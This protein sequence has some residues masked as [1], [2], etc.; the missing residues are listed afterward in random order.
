MPHLASHVLSRCLA[1]LGADWTA[2]YGYAPVLA[3]TFVNP[4]PVCRDV[5]PGGQLGAGRADG[6]AGHPVSQRQSGGRAQGH[7]CVP[8]RAPLE[9]G[10]VRGAGR[11]A[12]QHAAAGGP[13]RLDRRGVWHGAA[14]RRPPQAPAVHAGRRLLCAARRAGAA[15][16]RTARQPRRR[17]RTDFSRIPPWICTPCSGRT[18]SPPLTGSARTRSSWPC[19]TPPR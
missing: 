6:G 9:T 7:L 18:S 15:G 17:P 12:G 13:G 10:V 2:R 1:R 14:L 19:R 5:L 3:E 11:G 8:A 4:R 16:L